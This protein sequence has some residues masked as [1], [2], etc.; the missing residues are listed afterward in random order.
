M[1]TKLR[2]L[3]NKPNFRNELVMIEEMERM[4]VNKTNMR[5]ALIDLSSKLQNV[6]PRLKGR[7]V[8]YDKVRYLELQERCETL[9][10]DISR[11]FGDTEKHITDVNKLEKS[12]NFWL[13]R[14]EYDEA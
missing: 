2:Q 8:I 10:E 5:T 1:K 3:P 6:E 9:L 4:L 11:E 7:R 13:A 12:V 14:L